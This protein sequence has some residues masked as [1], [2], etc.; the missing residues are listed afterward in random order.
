MSFCVDFSPLRGSQSENGVA[1]GG[2]TCGR[3]AQGHTILTLRSAE[4][5]EEPE[6]APTLFNIQGDHTDTWNEPAPPG[7]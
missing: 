3:S 4:G 7:Q 5:A 6:R 2:T 1:L